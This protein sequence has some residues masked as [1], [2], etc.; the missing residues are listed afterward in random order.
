MLHHF[1]DFS[2]GRLIT[3][4]LCLIHLRFW[5]LLAAAEAVHYLAVVTDIDETLQTVLQRVLGRIKHGIVDDQC[6]EV[7]AGFEAAHLTKETSCRLGG[8]PE[9]LGQGQEGLVVV[10]LVVHLA[11]LDGIDQH[12][13]HVQVVTAADV[14]AQADVHILVKEGA[15]RCHT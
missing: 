10:L 9:Y 7:V 1:F 11:N 15:E 5:Y 2:V 8:N 12:A 3:H 4:H 6:I 13:E 14:A